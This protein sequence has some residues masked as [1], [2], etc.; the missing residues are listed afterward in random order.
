MSNLIIK[1]N[2]KK[3]SQ[4]K[5]DHFAFDIVG[6][7]GTY[8]EIGAN[9]PGKGSN[10]Y[11]LEVAAGWKG[12]SVELDTKWQAAWNECAERKN[13][14]YW[15]DAI[16]F[17]Y[18]KTLA[19]NSLPKHINYLSCDIEPPINTFNALKRVIEQGISFDVISFEHD[20]YQC[21]EDFHTVANTFLSR[22]GY[23]VAVYDVYFKNPTNTF[24]T[25]FIKDTVDFKTV[26]YSEWLV[27][28][29]SYQE[30]Q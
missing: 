28:I 24:E 22:Y 2:F 4:A 9:R 19:N 8:I 1:N 14:I 29:T 26:S 27:S 6:P 17:D 18:E 20:Q 5:Q 10:T 15:Q 11:N 12:F 7:N 23:K 21:D 13:P 25:W 30:K 3:C 16:T